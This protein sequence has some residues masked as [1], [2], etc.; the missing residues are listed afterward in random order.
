MMNDRCTR[1]GRPNGDVSRSNLNAR[2]SARFSA[3]RE[4][5]GRIRRSQKGR[6]F[7]I[8]KMKPRPLDVHLGYRGAVFIETG[9]PR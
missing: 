4:R 2:N 8:F 7:A 9:W 6:F 3:R 1:L 5:A